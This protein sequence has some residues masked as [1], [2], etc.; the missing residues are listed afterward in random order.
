MC[1][2]EQTHAARYTFSQTESR[3]VTVAKHCHGIHQYMYWVT[4]IMVPRGRWVDRHQGP[5][6]A[7]TRARDGQLGS[8]ALEGFKTKEMW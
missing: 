1:L 2:Y 4:A 8:T 3:G 6:G 7:N 5:T